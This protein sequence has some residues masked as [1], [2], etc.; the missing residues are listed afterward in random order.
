MIFKSIS[1]SPAL[2]EFVR[3]YTLLQ[4]KF[5]PGE[6][7]PYKYRP[8][9][10]EQGIVFYIKGCVNLQNTVTGSQQVPTTVSVFTHQTERKI[11][12][13]SP[14]FFMFSVF[15]P[16]GILHR[17]ISIPSMDLKQDYHDAELFF[18]QSKININVSASP[19]LLRTFSRLVL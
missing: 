19:F 3:N 8:P 11:F 5:T 12:Q 7:V 15:L 10:P 1:P 18:G 13:V 9:K 4:L 6:P 14:E 16:P 17:L 2:Q